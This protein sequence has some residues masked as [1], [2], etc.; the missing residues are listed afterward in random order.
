M[1]GPEATPGRLQ[2]VCSG[3]NP[4]TES[5][6][7]RVRSQEDR[8]SPAQIKQ[9]QIAA[10]THDAYATEYGAKLRQRRLRDR[11]RRLVVGPWPMAAL[12]F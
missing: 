8:L 5:G 7:H 9:R 4:D 11:V 3:V 12:L 1:I 6:E 10:V 2:S